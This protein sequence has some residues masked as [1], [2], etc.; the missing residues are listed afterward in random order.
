MAVVVPDKPAGRPAGTIAEPGVALVPL[1][2]A[3]ALALLLTIYPL[4][5]TTPA[6]KADHA[7]ATL[8]LWSMSAGFIRGVGFVP[9]N[10]LL[11]ILFSTAACILCL[12]LAAALIAR[13]SSLP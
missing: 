1:G 9:M 7:A 10:R 3:I 5:V 6:G 11:R 2:I 12:L 13:H 8:A 4:I